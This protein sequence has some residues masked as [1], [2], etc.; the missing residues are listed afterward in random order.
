MT[1]HTPEAAVTGQ[2]SAVVPAREVATAL[3]ETTTAACAA[4]L[5]AEADGW[6]VIAAEDRIGAG[7]VVGRGAVAAINRVDL[8]AAGLYPIL[9]AAAGL[10]AYALAATLGGSGFLAVYLAG[11]VIGNSRIVFHQG[12]FLFHDGL[13]WIGQMVMF[14][15][16][17]LLSTPSDLL[18]VAGAGLLVGA[19]LILVARP[20]AVVPLLL[21]FRFSL[22]EIVLVSWVGLKG[23][24]PIVLALYPLLYGFPDADLLFH[25]VFFVVLL[26]AVTQG[27][28]LPLV[29]RSLRLE[30]PALLQPP[31]A[32]EIVSLRD[33]DAD[34]VEYTLSEDSRAAGRRLDQ[35]A[36]PEGVVI[37]M[38][39]RRQSLIPPQRS[40]RL[41]VQDHVF[42][43]LKADMRP[44]VDRI[45][46]R[47]PTADLEPLAL[48]E[49]QLAGSVTVEALERSYG[50]T[51]GLPAHLTLD[52][53]IR[54][55][56]GPGVDE[57]SALDCGQATLRVLEMLDG[58]VATVA[59]LL[60][61]LPEDD[62]A[63]SQ[64][65]PSTD[66]RA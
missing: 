16:L 32:L 48:T 31:V 66:N 41:L 64:A 52:E 28:T 43:V 42:A 1:A 57:G 29:A 21:P 24:V 20:L 46:T 7:L 45:F 44:L 8:D 39:A 60:N 19:V 14:V 5:Q 27:W 34:I 59:V 22:R 37:A 26:S 9:T 62:D 53:A 63:S 49:F 54:T 18:E 15:V 40:T 61:D 2:G 50:V 11:I 36:L 47:Y 6:V 58:K 56:V 17:G 12:T 51:L 25:V 30:E 23:A 3:V 55:A 4:V 35:L 38:I 10:F 13:A 65:A 33:V